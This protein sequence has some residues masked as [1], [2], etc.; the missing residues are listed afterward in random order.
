MTEEGDFSFQCDGARN[1]TPV[2]P[3]MEATDE[4]GEGGFD[5]RG[6]GLLID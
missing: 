6:K 5:P 3:E 2:R 4:A 1:E